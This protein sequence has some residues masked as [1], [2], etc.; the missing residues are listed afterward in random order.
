M[1]VDG[2]V[3]GT[4]L[5]MLSFLYHIAGRRKEERETAERAMVADVVGPPD[6][7]V[8]SWLPYSLALAAA[9]RHDEAAAFL[10]ERISSAGQI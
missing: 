8:Y 1:P 2:P 6:W 3:I 9:G 4:N 10:R 7:A 5:A